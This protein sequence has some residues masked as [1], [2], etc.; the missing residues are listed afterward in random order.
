MSAAVTIIGVLLLLW[1]G[2]HAPVGVYLVFGSDE[3]ERNVGQSDPVGGLAPVLHMLA[4]RMVLIGTVFLV[5]GATE[6]LAGLGVLWRKPWGRILALVMEGWRIVVGLVSLSAYNPKAAENAGPI[7]YGAAEI[8]FGVLAVLILT[9]KG[10]GF[11]RASYLWR[12]MP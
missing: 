10:A 7:A 12:T 9:I 6:I 1:G 8:L 11:S 5:Q 3:F 2:A 4:G